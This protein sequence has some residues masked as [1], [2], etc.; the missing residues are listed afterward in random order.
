MKILIVRLSAMGD[1]IHAMPAVLGLRHAFP[2]CKIDWAIEERWSSLL[3]ALPDGSS[4]S[5]R[6]L[7]QEQPLVN[8]VHPVGMRHWRRTPFSNNT[9]REV[10]A[11]RAQLR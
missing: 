1:V 7:S 11:L 9:L 10:R 6:T 3:T 4:T 5:S 8:A 2:E